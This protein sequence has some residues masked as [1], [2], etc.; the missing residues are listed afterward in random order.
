MKDF[1][2]FIGELASGSANDTVNDSG[3]LRFLQKIV[4][5]F[6]PIGQPPV[7]GIAPQRALLKRACGHAGSSKGLRH[8][9]VLPLPARG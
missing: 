4:M 8:P 1:V 2:P 6:L 7:A 9:D 3:T 5:T